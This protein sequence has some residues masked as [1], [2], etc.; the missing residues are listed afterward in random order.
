[1]NEK[2]KITN[3]IV[4]QEIFGKVGNERITKAFLRKVLGIEIEDLTLDTNKRLYGELIDDK[5]GRID[6]KAKLSDGTKVIIEMQ[7]TRYKYMAQRLLYYWAGTYIGDLKKGKDYSRLDKTIAI[8][9][10]VQDLEE[11]EGIEDYH[12]KW[13]LVDIE[14]LDKR[15]TEDLEIHVIE[16]NKF[17]EGKDIP[18]DNGIKFIKGVDLEMIEEVEEEIREA[19]EELERITADPVMREKYEAREKYLR[20]KVS[21]MSAALEEAKE[22]G[23]KIGIEQGIL[24]GREEGKQQGIEQGIKEGREEGIKD[25]IAIAQKEMI[26][27][28]REKDFT[29]KEI[30]EIVKLNEEEVK[31]IIKNNR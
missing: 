23:W 19:R 20:D 14:H 7:V 5:I 22:R 9:L 6:V 11:L 28:L 27:N 17:K 16:L 25:G 4:F 12:T 30:S 2:I 18:E 21:F 8:L 13:E 26:I 10:S 29:I 24:Q 15:L 31:M 3:D 1:M